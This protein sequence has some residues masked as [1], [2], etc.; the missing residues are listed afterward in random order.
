MFLPYKPGL[1]HF[2]IFLL[3]TLVINIFLYKKYLKPYNE[4]DVMI[5]KI[6]QESKTRKEGKKMRGRQFYKNERCKSP[7]NWNSDDGCS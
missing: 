3:P 6:M 1:K 7:P 4:C 5:Y 2:Y